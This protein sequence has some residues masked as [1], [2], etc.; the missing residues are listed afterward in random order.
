[1]II[2]SCFFF[3]VRNCS[4]LMVIIFFSSVV[5]VWT[6]NTRR[7]YNFYRKKSKYS[8]KLGSVLQ[9]CRFLTPGLTNELK[10]FFFS[11]SKK[12]RV[13][14]SKQDKSLLLVKRQ[15][16]RHMYVWRTATAIFFI[17]RVIYK[18]VSHFIQFALFKEM[19]AQGTCFFYHLTLTSNTTP[20]NITLRI[21]EKKK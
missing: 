1:M 21:L 4:F 6:F 7:V 13:I 2:W 9:W 18:L 8:S 5:L 12:F 3:I 19:E 15:F 17:K 20:I 16:G 10:S 14:Y 11:K